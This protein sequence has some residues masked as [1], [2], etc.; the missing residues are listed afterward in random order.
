MFR[1]FHARLL[2]PSSPPASRIDPSGNLNE[3]EAPRGVSASW[4]SSSWAGPVES[5]LVSKWLAVKQKQS[6]MRRSSTMFY[7]LKSQFEGKE[8]QNHNLKFA[9]GVCLDVQVF[10]FEPFISERWSVNK[11]RNKM[12][13]KRTSKNRVELLKM[14][15]KPTAHAVRIL[16]TLYL[17]YFCCQNVCYFM[18]LHWYIMIH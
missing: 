16:S 12:G 11:S 13:A 2:G 5:P 14:G 10:G 17:P 15:W 6:P 8:L 18:S 4:V 7:N 3:K 1:Q 9:C